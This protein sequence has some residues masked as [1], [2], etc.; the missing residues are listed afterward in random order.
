[1]KNL[2]LILL[3]LAFCPQV[4]AA[5]NA[6]LK[7]HPPYFLRAKDKVPNDSLVCPADSILDVRGQTMDV[8]ANI[9][10][11]DADVMDQLSDPSL[12]EKILRTKSSETTTGRFYWHSA[13][14]LDY[15]HFQDMEGNHWY[16]WADGGDF[17][18][19]LSRGHRYWWHDP[20]AKHWLYYYHGYWWRSDGQTKDVLQVCVDG[21]YYTC[22]SRGR[23]VADMGRDGSGGITSAPGRYQGDSHHG[24]SHGGGHGE[25]HGAGDAGQG[26]PNSPQGGGQAGSPPATQP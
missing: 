4:R 23:V 20:F 1:M 19:I 12:F 10:P 9:A 15:C 25:G 3:V 2:W 22:D 11:P 5:N 26:S 17:N 6:P 21:E 13:G 18:W 8:S 16:G 7:V 24:G 14:D